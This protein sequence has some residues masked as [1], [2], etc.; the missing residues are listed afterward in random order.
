[1]PSPLDQWLEHAIAQDHGSLPHHT[2]T[3]KPVIENTIKPEDAAKQLVSDVTSNRDS[4]DTAYRFWNLVFRTAATFPPYFGV[5]VDL[6]LAIYDVPSGS[7][8]FKGIERYFWENWQDVY[9]DYYTYRTL[10]SS[11]GTNTPNNAKRWIN[12]THF[13]AILLHQS[14]KEVFVKEIG[15]HAFFDLRN[16]LKITVQTH[17]TKT[18]RH[19]SVVSAR[20][21]ME[22]D[23]VAA[24]QWV[25]YA[26]TKLLYLENA[27]FGNHWTRGLS[28]KTELWDGEPGFSKARWE[29]WARRFEESAKED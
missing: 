29:V 21:A 11:A 8:G 1:M 14:D 19:N 15:I 6:V 7:E 26:G 5:I 2:Q 18:L 12:F 13:S 25:I 28:Q 24:A 20:Q 10:A 16:A 27:G 17:G 4:A 9:S 23:V 3:L 22:T